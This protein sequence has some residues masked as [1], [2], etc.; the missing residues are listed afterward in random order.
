[1]NRYVLTFSFP[2]LLTACYGS[3]PPHPA[4]V[5]L[6]TFSDEAVMNVHTKQRTMMETHNAEERT[7][8][9]DAKDEKDP[10]CTVTT[11]EV[12]RPV[13]RVFTTATLGTD[14]INYAQFRVLT[15]PAYTQK[16]AR[17]DRLSASCRHADTPRWIGTAMMLGGLVTT[18]VGAG[19]KEPAVTVTGGG[20]MAGGI[21]A[22]VLGY[23]KFNG[24]DC[25]RARD[26]YDEVDLAAE[27]RWAEAE[28]AER[29]AEMKILA[30]QFNASHH[31]QASTAER[32]TN[33]NLP[34]PAPPPGEE[35]STAS[36]PSPPLEPAVTATAPAP[37]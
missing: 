36:T 5:A 32:T 15:D 34:P 7:C 4:P 16:V 37:Q 2:L 12:T 1:M 17:L 20:T 9:A 11:R 14:D 35:P 13:T 31:V 24:S 19:I 29:A 33:E 8:P 21:G 6:P 30:A 10:K 27:S 22:V 28:G 25:N 23:T 3:A 26:L 18:L